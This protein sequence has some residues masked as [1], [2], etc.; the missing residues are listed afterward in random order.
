MDDVT[1]E[2]MSVLLKSV[3][4]K[5][6]ISEQTYHTAQSKLVTFSNDSGSNFYAVH[7]TSTETMKGAD[8]CGHSKDSIRNDDGENHL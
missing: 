6:L 5:K 1:V 4:E 8:H 2:M 3:Y 7:N